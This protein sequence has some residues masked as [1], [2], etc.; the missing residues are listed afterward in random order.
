MYV[1]AKSV[2]TS[3][4]GTELVALTESKLVGGFPSQG[5]NYVSTAILQGGNWLSRYGLALDGVTDDSAALQAALN[6][7]A[8][9]LWGMAGQVCYC[10]SGINIPAGVTLQGFGFVNAT[11]P[12]VVG[13]ELLFANSVPTCVTISSTAGNTGAGLRGVVI[14][15]AGGTPPGG[16]IGLLAQHSYATILEDIASYNHA[17]PVYVNGTSSGIAISP[18]RI[19]TGGATDAHV[20]IENLPEVRFNQSRLGTNGT[21]DVSCNAYVRFKG[22]SWNTVTFANCQFNQGNTGGHNTVGTWFDYVSCTSTNQIVQISDC[23]CE[24]ASYAVQTDAASTHIHKLFLVNAYFAKGLD[25]T[26]FFNLNAATTVENFYMTNC[27]VGGTFTFA[28]TPAFHDVL[29]SNTRFG[30]PVSVTGVSGSRCSFSG[31]G[32]S[33]N[34]TVAGVFAHALFSGELGGTLTN[35]STSPIELDFPGSGQDWTSYTPTLSFGGGNTGITYSIQSG[36]YKVLGGGLCVVEV[37]LNLSSKG[38]STGTAKL[39]GLPFTINTGRAVSGMGNCVTLNSGMSSLSTGA[40]M[41]S[42]NGGATTATFIQQ[43]ATGTSGI[44]DSNF[45][46]SSIIQTQ[47]MF[48]VN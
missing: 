42:P 26:E 9:V 19:Y 16:S 21:F 31:C 47:F 5:N 38:S 28:P 43:T 7:G 23:Y 44:T 2:L 20:V 27:E 36:R 33:N 10:A 8:K 3:L 35:S 39:E 11:P 34:L 46:D 18:N 37:Q 4:D 12:T 29:V 25:A 15:R 45:T 24:S 22:D 41:I 6:S 13:F 17:V 30:P 32:F 48:A 40:L 1:D 14:N